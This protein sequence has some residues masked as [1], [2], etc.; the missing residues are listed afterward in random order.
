M[1]RLS[2]RLRGI[3]VAAL[4]AVAATPLS[5]CDDPA[6][7]AVPASL[8]GSAAPATGTP[9]PAAS[10]S[11]S[12]APSTAPSP[13]AT[14]SPRPKTSPARPATTAAKPPTTCKPKVT[15]VYGSNS[16]VY[17]RVVDDTM[18]RSAVCRDRTIPVW[19]VNY[20]ANPDR[21]GTK[22]LAKRYLL[23]HASPS[24]QFK[25]DGIFGGWCYSYHVVAFVSSVPST[26]PASAMDWDGSYDYWR[27]R[28]GERM[29]QE[30]SNVG[31]PA[32]NP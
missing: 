31:C 7:D 13:V 29:Y 9:T 8:A 23:S 12:T 14:S 3:A 32:G 1:Y 24:M 10:S 21:T 4:L 2:V 19:R 5:A 18:W 15:V 16:A 22:E 25:G 11:A 26:L 17:V 20:H 6:R 28:G 30:D 27:R